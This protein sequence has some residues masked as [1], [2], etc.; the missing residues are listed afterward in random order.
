MW[1]KPNSPTW[2]PIPAMMFHPCGSAPCLCWSFSLKE[3]FTFFT[4]LIL[5]EPSRFSSRFRG[6]YLN[7]ILQI[8]QDSHSPQGRHTSWFWQITLS[9]I[10]GHLECLWVF[11]SPSCLS[12]PPRLLPC[13]LVVPA[14]SYTANLRVAASN[15]D[16]SL[17]KGFWMEVPNAT[18][19]SAWSFSASPPICIDLLEINHESK[20]WY[21]IGE[22]CYLG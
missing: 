10:R 20:W 6:K 21:H 4:Q 19:H 12:F 13:L 7:Q 18:P 16:D 14:V 8:P 2:I 3:L 17:P 5:T 9:Y 15:W 1:R 11:L 22:H